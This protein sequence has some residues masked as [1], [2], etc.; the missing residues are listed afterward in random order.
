M[1]TNVRAFLDMLAWSEIGPALLAKSDNGYNVLVGS[2]PE[3]PLLFDSYADHPD[4]YNRECDSTAAGRYQILHRY[5]D[6][7]RDL[8]DLPDFGPE[9]QDRYAIQQIKEQGGLDPLESGDLE[10]AIWKCSN[11]WAS[12]PGNDYDQHTNP[13]ADLREAYVNA[14]GILSCRRPS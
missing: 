7:Y 9:S 1:N 11:I 14:G 6:H 8:L 3:N 5:W 10:Q 4:V 13:I 12:L 2:T